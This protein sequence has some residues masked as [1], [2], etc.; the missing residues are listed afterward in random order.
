VK[1][2]ATCSGLE[3]AQPFRKN[4]SVILDLISALLL[5]LLGL[6]PICFPM[7][8]GITEAIARRLNSGDS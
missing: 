4:K 8:A 7:V 3:F 2:I 5:L 6:Q 1:G